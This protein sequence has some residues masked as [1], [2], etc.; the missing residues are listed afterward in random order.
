MTVYCKYNL[1]TI[2]SQSKTVALAFF[3]N[4]LSTETNIKMVEAL[5]SNKLNKLLF[6]SE[7]LVR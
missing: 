6:Y 2:S 1:I 4:N 5:K 7:K 3:D